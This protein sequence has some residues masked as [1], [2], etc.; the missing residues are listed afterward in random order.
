MKRIASVLFFF[1]FCFFAPCFSVCGAEIND[2]VN[3]PVRWEGLEVKVRGE[4]VGDILKGEGGSFWIN[5][6]DG[7]SA[8][9]VFLPQKLAKNLEMERWKGGNY[10][11]K[12]TELMI[13]GVFNSAC[14]E[15]GGDLDLHAMEVRLIRESRSIHHPLSFL[16]VKLALFLFFVALAFFLFTRS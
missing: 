7:E 9:G 14:A 3:E 4:I 2:L 15:H 1:F 6:S 11:V 8:I 12:G 16:K 13:K 5:V 10:L